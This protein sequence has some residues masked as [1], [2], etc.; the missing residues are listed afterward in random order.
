MIQIT[1]YF[2]KFM[3]ITSLKIA[4]LF[5]LFLINV[6]FSFGIDKKDTR[7]LMQPAIGAG[8][9]AFV[10]AEQIWIANLDGSQARRL[11]Q[12]KGVESNPVFSPDGKMVAFTARYNGNTDV[13]II[14]VNGGVL[15]RLTWH[16]A[17][18]VVRGFTPD[19]KSVL[20]ASQRTTFTSAVIGNPLSKLFTVQ[21]SGGPATEL[22]IPTAYH[23][24]YSPNGMNMAYT[25][26]PDA[27][28]QWKHYRG[29][30]SSTIYLF[31][32]AD[33]SV[34]KIPKPSGGSNDSQPIW[35]KG[36]IYFRSDRNGEMN[37]FSYNVGS[38]T[39]RQLTNF[40]DFPVLNAS[41]G[42]GKIIFEQAGYLHQYDPVLEKYK[43]ITVGIN[44]QLA[45]LESRQVDGKKYF[46]SADIYGDRTVFD[47]R[48]EIIT[49]SAET[50]GYQNLT[51]STGAHEKYPVWSADGKSIAYFSDASGEFKLDINSQDGLVKSFKLQGTGFYFNP[52]W[53]PDGK[54][55]AYSDNGRNL[56]ILN[57]ESGAVVKVD[58]DDIFQIGSSRDFFCSWTPDS[59]SVAY[60]KVTRT[61]YK[62]IIVFTI[63]E[64]KYNELTDG[65]SDASEPQFSRD[66][67]YLYFFISTDAGPVINWSDQSSFNARKTNAIYLVTL[68]NETTSP[69]MKTDTV[70]VKSNKQVT[71]KGDSKVQQEFRIDWKGIQ[72]RILPFPVRAGNYEH[73]SVTENG[74]ILYMEYAENAG[75]KMRKYSLKSYTDS[76]ILNMDS[77]IL[78]SDGKKMLYNIEGNW[79]IANAGETTGNMPV[80]LQTVKIDIDP[81]AEWI[82]VYN[83]AWRV[84]RDYFY[85]P[86]MHGVDWLAIKKKYESF[87]PDIS[88]RSDLNLLLQWVGSELAVSH[89]LIIDDGDKIS[90]PENIKTGLLG[91]DYSVYKNRYQFKKIYGGLNWTP[92]LRSPLTAPGINLSEGDFLL[93][94][95]GKNILATEDIYQYFEN[96]ADQVLS[97]TVGPNPDYRGARI[98]KILPVENEYDLRNRDWVEGNLE[99]VTQASKGQVAYVYVPN[100]GKNGLD[101]FKRYFYPQADRKAIII[102]ERF[103]GGGLI[104]DYYINLLNNPYQAN[105]NTRYGK[106]VKSPS[107]SIQ[108]PKV[109]LINESA[110]SGGDMLPWMFKKFKMGTLIGTRTWGGLVGVLD[111]PE[112]LDGGKIT[113]PNWGVWT[114]DGWQIENIGVTPDIEV[115]QLPHQ[116][117]NGEDPQLQKAIETVLKELEANP[118]VEPIRP[119]YPV[120]VSTTRTQIH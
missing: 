93:A 19:G 119:P 38:K 25:A 36:I 12:K 78:S 15:K 31:S 118:P 47:L 68:Q 99:R 88:C 89:S 50:G 16:P 110:G 1:Y 52:K 49:L 9:I 43:K 113:A 98:V 62:K 86:N 115:E 120:K 64:N 32:F 114:E 109:M 63:A 107:A 105:W 23:A 24:S 35:L 94:L 92:D 100:T 6:A 70:E 101:Y 87:L 28:K 67:K 8:H 59:K 61:Y 44:T 116:V 26:I 96:K 84:Q 111:M 56:Y 55:I 90:Q 48:G 27:F 73:L 76:E 91:A 13:Y 71:Q 45:E 106:D 33:H 57:I 80:Q 95:D 18:D 81:T 46:R 85:D 104:A 74:D 40:T 77:Y 60:T 11:S 97:L 108:G 14:P 10:Y 29:G 5:I 117:I 37:L 30:Q 22:E 83:E 112:L 39:V 7:M 53:S 103:N 102:D 4:L 41:G 51:N 42:N 82:N 21:V 72:K 34:I 69:L 2:S 58:S 66:G 75:G 65:M 20:F 54:K 79:F 17:E 3:K